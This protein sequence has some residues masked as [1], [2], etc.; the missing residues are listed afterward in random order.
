VTW[1]VTCPL[2]DTAFAMG[3]AAL[4]IRIQV[5]A[6]L[7]HTRG[8]APRKSRPRS[9][10]RAI[11]GRHRLKQFYSR[12]RPIRLDSRSPPRGARR[13]MSMSSPAHR[14]R[15]RSLQATY[16]RRVFDSRQQVGSPDRFFE[17]LGALPFCISAWASSHS[18]Q[19]PIS[20]FLVQRSCLRTRRSARR[21]R[22]RRGTARIERAACRERNWITCSWRT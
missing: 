8:R 9:P 10:F 5:F 11:A 3:P 20:C 1:R 13:T 19:A 7:P 4:A 21:D 16:P 2:R 22:P 6:R 18:E 15:G 12:P 14:S 17:E